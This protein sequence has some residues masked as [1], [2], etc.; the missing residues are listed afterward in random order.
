M[1]IIFILLFMGM[2]IGF[3]IRKAF[4]KRLPDDGG[5]L[6]V[7]VLSMLL[8]FGASI[9][10]NADVMQDIHALGLKGLYYGLAALAGAA[11][12]CMLLQNAISGKATRSEVRQS[13]NKITLKTVM[14]SLSTL[15]SFSAGIII[16]VT[17]N[18]PVW[19]NP[20]MISELLLYLLIFTVAVGIGNRQSLSS[21]INRR[22]LSS[23]LIPF[24]SIAG[25]FIIGGILGLLPTGVGLGDSISAV[26]GMGY[27][28]LSSVLIT[29]LK[30]SA[31]GM[32]AAIQLGAIALIS[33]IVRELATLVLAPWIFS[34]MGTFALIGAA[35]VTSMDVCLPTITKVC[36]EEAAAPA[37]VNG[38][39]LEILT[40]FLITLACLL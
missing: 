30:A 7:V 20:S 2:L 28:S 33:N 6:T 32:T 16:G 39:I 37:L 38:I 25:T 40:P 11:L 21:I 5:F 31:I 13:A 3:L 15:I 10:T 22:N 24:A 8:C 12:A 36:G 27:Y 26:S 34:K 29:N 23:L 1:A 14:G 4:P 9:G 18:L 19:V 17:L 35:G